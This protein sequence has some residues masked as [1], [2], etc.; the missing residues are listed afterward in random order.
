MS[1]DYLDLIPNDI[2][3]YIAIEYLSL[4]DVLKLCQTCKRFNNLIYNNDNYWRN[5]CKKDLNQENLKM[6]SG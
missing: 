2:I 5:R 3:Y 4:I 1:T 6:A